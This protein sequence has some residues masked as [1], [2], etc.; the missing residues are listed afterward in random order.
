MYRKKLPCIIN[1]RFEYDLM[2]AGRLH[3]L[4][5]H[6]SYT[7]GNYR[8]K[9][10]VHLHFDFW[11]TWINWRLKFAV[12][13]TKVKNRSLFNLFYY[14]I[15]TTFKKFRWTMDGKNEWTL[16]FCLKLSKQLKTIYWLKYLG[17]SSF[18]MH[19]I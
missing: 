19:V 8:S 3:Q 15:L 12:F 10:Y 2:G 7:K 16:K 9:H 4:D 6:D 18:I 14:P 1:R 13:F 5:S 17:N 11:C